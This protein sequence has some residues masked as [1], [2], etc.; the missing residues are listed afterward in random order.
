[1]RRGLIGSHPKE[2][3]VVS[4]LAKGYGGK[5]IAYILNI[6]ENSVKTHI[7]N[8]SHRRKAKNRIHLILLY[9]EETGKLNNHAVRNPQEIEAYREL[10]QSIQAS[11]C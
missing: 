4:W 9:L 1:M 8:A 10:P 7:M 11:E 2:D 6:S 5:E 3:E